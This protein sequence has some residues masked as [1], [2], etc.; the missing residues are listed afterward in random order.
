MPR[1]FVFNPLTP[2]CP[3]GR[4]TLSPEGRGNHGFVA[5]ALIRKL[6]SAMPKVILKGKKVIL[7]PFVLDDARRFAEWLSDPEVTKFL[8]IYDQPPPTLKEE[9]DYIKRARKDKDNLRFAIDTIEGRHI[10]SIGL[11]KI[12]KFHKRAD[13]GIFIG[14]KKYWGQGYGTE[15]CKL[16]VG[17]GFKK[18]KL[19]R[20]HLTCIAYNI[21][22]QKSYEKV[23]FKVEGY[24]RDHIF[25]DGYFHDEIHMG[26]LRSEYFKKIRNLK[27]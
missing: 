27:S 15:A 25:R 12:D 26:L 23:G 24:L 1:L 20:I 14:D 22:G 8:S 10:G 16:I 17:H 3:A 2:A 4:P 19:H 18:L 21:R 11:N 5:F 6:A 13:Y 9:R 7:R